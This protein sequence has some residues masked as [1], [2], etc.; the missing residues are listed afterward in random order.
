VNR[1]DVWKTHPVVV[2]SLGSL[3][4]LHKLSA[5]FASTASAKVERELFYLFARLRVNRNLAYRYPAIVAGVGASFAVLVVVIL[6]EWMRG[7]LSSVHWGPFP[8]AW[9]S[10]FALVGAGASTLFGYTTLYDII[11][12]KQGNNR[13]LCG[14]VLA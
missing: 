2:F 6:S 9:R 12:V 1:P 5:S 3:V 13:L 11:E 8:L 7:R 14:I 4:E 10:R